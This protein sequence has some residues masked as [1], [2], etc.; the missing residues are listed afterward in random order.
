[1]RPGN[2]GQKGTIVSIPDAALRTVASWVSQVAFAARAAHLVQR[3]RLGK[4]LDGASAATC[5]WPWPGSAWLARFRSCW[6]QGCG[7]P[8]ESW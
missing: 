4:V 8:C 6:C 2:A 5:A 1:M 3:R 7:R